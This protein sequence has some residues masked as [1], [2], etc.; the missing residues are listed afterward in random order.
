MKL[1]IENKNKNRRITVSDV[2]R[3]AGVS[4]STVSR[5]ISGN[6]RI[7][8]STRD[9][10]FKIMKEMNYI[11]NV[12]GRSLAM[13]RTGVVGVVMPHRSSDS[14]LNPFFPEALRG[15]VNAAANHGYDVLIS[16]KGKDKDELSVIRQLESSGRVDGIILL[17]SKEWDPNIRYLK[18]VDFPFTVVGSDAGFNTNHVN[19][20]NVSAAKDLTTHMI[21]SGR[22]DIIFA[23]GGM[24]YSV[25]RERI[26]GFKEALEKGGLKF[27][28]DLIYTGNFDE[29]TGMRMA[30]EILK[31]GR[32]IDAVIASDDV[33]AFGMVKTFL[34][35]G[36]EIPE[37]IAIASFN[38]SV[39][40]R[41]SECPL[42]SVDINAADLGREALEQVL[43]AIDGL[44]G[45]KILV[46]YEVIMRRS[47]KKI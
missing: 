15:I 3:K 21:E 42:T 16:S 28:P 12:N 19:N 18:G 33:I 37:K 4:P 36:V 10:V 22:K 17:S 25:T 35:K 7:S 23:A 6:P 27:S 39:L 29:E 8:A 43:K 32:K 26:E 38:N 41:Y 2:A 46:P 13:N 14:L 40:S 31:S 24:E 44:R 1:K 5:V 20:D 47:T 9:K 11:P 30:E 45:E 34:D